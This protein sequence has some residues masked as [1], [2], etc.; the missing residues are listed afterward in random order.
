MP[1]TV[2]DPLDRAPDTEAPAAVKPLLKD[3]AVP[4]K[5]PDD[6]NELTTAAP[7]AAVVAVSGPVL[8]LW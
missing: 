8:I 2:A 3:R 5:A 4:D 7:R 6:C 1:V